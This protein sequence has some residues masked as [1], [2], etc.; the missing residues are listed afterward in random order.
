MVL[1]VHSNTVNKK[2]IK[3]HNVKEES[4]VHS[5]L[6]TG[7][8]SSTL[9]L[10]SKTHNKNR[11][12]NVN[13]KK[14]DAIFLLAFSHTT[15]RV[16]VSPGGSPGHLTYGSRYGPLV[17]QLKEKNENKQDEFN[18]NNKFKKTSNNF[19]KRKKKIYRGKGCNKESSLCMMSTNATE[20]KND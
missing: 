14:N 7:A 15:C 19:I 13:F 8:S 16:F 6:R 18:A 1:N 11:Q 4:I 9:F 2:N 5:M 3:F 20:G 12:R 17:E 10:I